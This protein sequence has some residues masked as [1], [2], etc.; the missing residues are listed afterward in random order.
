MN[1]MLV[2]LAAR[3]RTPVGD[4]YPAPIPCLDEFGTGARRYILGTV[5][6]SK[7]NLER[8]LWQRGKGERRDH[9]RLGSELNP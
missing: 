5:W 6:P 1:I 2:M 8:Y 3:D 7:E 4:P 9:R